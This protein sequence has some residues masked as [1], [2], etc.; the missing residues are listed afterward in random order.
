MNETIQECGVIYAVPFYVGIS[1][2]ETFLLSSVVDRI[3]VVLQI[4]SLSSSIESRIIAQ[5]VD[6]LNCNYANT[7]WRDFWKALLKFASLWSS[8]TPHDRDFSIVKVPAQ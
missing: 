2:I 3:T 4:K 1:I 8:I 6:A 5:R 7:Y